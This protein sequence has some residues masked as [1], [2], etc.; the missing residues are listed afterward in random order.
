MPNDADFK[1][2]IASEAKAAMPIRNDNL[3]CKDCVYKYD[4]SEIPGNTSKC[5]IYDNKPNAI[6]LGG[7]CNYKEEE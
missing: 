4:D 2:R 5:E 1:K 7:K 3:D 6:L